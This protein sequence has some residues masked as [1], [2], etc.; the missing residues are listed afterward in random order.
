[1]HPSKKINNYCIGARERESV[2][3]AWVVAVYG[4]NFKERP[5]H[6]GDHLD[7][8]DGRESVPTSRPAPREGRHIKFTSLALELPILIVTAV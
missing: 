5:S 6:Q 8:L 7:H 4:L 3:E 1:M 2:E